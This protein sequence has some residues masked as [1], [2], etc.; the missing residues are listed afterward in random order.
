MIPA[1]QVVGRILRVSGLLSATDKLRYFA[2]IAR[3]QRRNRKFVSANPGF[4]LPPKALAFDAYSAPDWAFYKRS[5]L[6]TAAFLSEISRK[7][8]V[9][10]PEI[11]VF[12]WGC[13]PARVIRH[14]PTAFGA[15]AQIYGSDFNEATIAWCR[16]TIPRV[17]FVRN[18][19][20]PDPPLPFERDFF[21][22]IYSISVFTHLSESTSQRWI[23]ELHRVARPGG[24]LVITTNGDSLQYKMLP[25]ELRSYRTSGIVI[26]GKIREGKK[27]FS[28]CH[29]PRYLREILFKDFD[30]MEH[31]PGAFPHTAQDFWVLRKRS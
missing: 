5:G 3:L 28:A 20:R 27:M 29:S 25:D 23:L 2:S 9:A 30:V 8:L 24:V 6:E 14:L 12:E 11:N 21:D 1:R 18:A 16:D 31:V 15:D 4:R 13:G 17:T 7:Y 10:V 26:R 19:L 22:F